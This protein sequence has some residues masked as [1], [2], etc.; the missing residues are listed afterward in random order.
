MG[1]DVKSDKDLV[2]GTPVKT[3]LKIRLGGWFTNNA[4][5]VEIFRM[6]QKVVMVGLTIAVLMSMIHVGNEIVTMRDELKKARAT[7]ESMQKTIADLTTEIRKGVKV[8]LW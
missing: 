8:R 6:I 7:I 3:P 1:E 2:T 4:M 5:Y